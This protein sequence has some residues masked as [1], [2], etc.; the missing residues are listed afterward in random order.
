[1][2]WMALP[3]LLLAWAL[4]ETGSWLGR[5]VDGFAGKG[6]L[7]GLAVVLSIPGVLFAAY[8]LHWFDGVAWFYQLRSLPLSEL[9]AGGM[10]LLA[11]L[12]A[13]GA[14]GLR[15]VSRPFLMVVLTAG[16]VGPYLKP[17]MA[18]IP[19]ARFQDRW[20]DGVCLQSTAS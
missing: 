17:V 12:L 14:R 5:R 6:L 1:M 15:V 20:V 8:Y 16:V 2:N 3:T 10:G 18:P 19:R 4:F 13:E 9:S 7:L 11:G